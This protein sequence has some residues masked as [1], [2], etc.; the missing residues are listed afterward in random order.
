M[1]GQFTLRIAC[2]PLFDRGRVI[3]RIAATPIALVFNLLR[4][5]NAARNRHQY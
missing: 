2:V 5:R 4:L 3:E 1:S